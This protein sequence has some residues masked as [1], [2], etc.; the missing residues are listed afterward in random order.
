MVLRPKNRKFADTGRDFDQNRSDVERYVGIVSVP[1]LSAVTATLT[2]LGVYYLTAAIPK[3][4]VFAAIVGRPYRGLFEPKYGEVTL[5]RHHIILPP[6]GTSLIFVGVVLGIVSG[7]ALY[8]AATKRPLIPKVRE[9]LE[10]TDV[11]AELSRQEELLDELRTLPRVLA[12]H[13]LVQLAARSLRVTQEFTNNQPRL[14]KITAKLMSQRWHVST[15][16]FNLDRGPK[17]GFLKYEPNGDFPT[18]RQDLTWMR[19]RITWALALFFWALSFVIVIF[20]LIFDA[21]IWHV[22]LWETILDLGLAVLAG[23]LI[24]ATARTQLIFYC[25][26]AVR[27]EQLIQQNN[28]LSA[29]ITKYQKQR[30]GG[31]R[32]V[33]RWALRWLADH[34]V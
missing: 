29:S 9:R 10:Q 20:Y 24:Y 15:K 3:S 26:T 18:L 2:A 31:V 11:A 19:R 28:T 25:R 1:G 4:G 32:R 14:L 13:R 23:L 30:S 8:N 7:Y 22:E 21:I 16:S 27:Q 12:Q 5:R 6:V 34:V 17:Y 33:I